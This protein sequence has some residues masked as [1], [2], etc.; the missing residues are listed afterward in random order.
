MYV[1][2]DK[3]IDPQLKNAPLVNVVVAVNVDVDIVPI[4]FNLYMLSVAVL[5]H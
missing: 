5:C 2:A 4:A 3:V 1:P